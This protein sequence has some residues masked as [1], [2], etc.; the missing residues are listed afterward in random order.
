VV[1]DEPVV[2]TAVQRV[3]AS[4]GYEVATTGRGRAA[5]CHPAAEVCDLVLCDLVLPDVSGNEVVAG[6]HHRRPGLPIVLITGYASSESMRR[7]AEAGA[8]S[9][10]AKPFDPE[11]LL[12]AVRGALGQSDGSAVGK[13]MP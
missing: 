3:L 13:E 10:L 2:S 12:E 9:F 4:A 5:L 7:A 8:V 11:E 6:L 1:D